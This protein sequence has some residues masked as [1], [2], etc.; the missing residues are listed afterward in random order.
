MNVGTEAVLTIPASAAY[1]NKKMDDIPANSTLTF[2]AFVILIAL[3]L[4]RLMP[5]RMRRGQ[6]SQH[7]VNVMYPFPKR[8]LSRAPYCMVG[9]PWYQTP[10]VFSL[11][12]V[13]ECCCM[14]CT[15]KRHCLFVSKSSLIIPFSINSPTYRMSVPGAPPL[16]QHKSDRL[17][18][19]D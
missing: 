13:S 15:T 12:K 6:S 16:L 17:I 9:V 11:Q 10:T 8:R 2:G 14:R 5:N 4:L 7:Q 1:G 19:R 18:Q 3:T